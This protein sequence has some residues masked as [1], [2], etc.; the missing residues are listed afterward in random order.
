VPDLSPPPA[1]AEA[2]ME[3]SQ[4][5]WHTAA[6]LYVAH[7]GAPV[8]SWAYG[9]V[10]PGVPMTTDTRF[11]TTCAGKPILAVALAQTVEEGSVAWDEPA[12]TWVPE[13]GKAGKGGIEIRHLVTYSSGLPE[14]SLPPDRAEAL[15]Q[16]AGAPLDYEP[17]TVSAY[18]GWPNW[19]LVGEVLRRVDGVDL[20]TA[21]QRRIFGR[22]GATLVTD[23]TT[24]P[25]AVVSRT[26][27]SP[28]EPIELRQPPA[29]EWWIAYQRLSMR[30]LGSFYVELAR[31]DSPLLSRET[32][33]F[34]LEPRARQM[35]WWFG[36][37]K[38]SFSWSL[39]FMLDWDG[40]FPYFPPRTFGYD[41][42]PISFAF[43]DPDAELVVAFAA[44]GAPGNMKAWARTHEITEAIFETYAP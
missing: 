2:V 7:R 12:A 4:I 41:G 3:G 30:D 40:L 24:P 6:Q 34:M 23:S 32:L 17:G 29:E 35:P 33:E 13:L 20:P 25:A 36:G 15:A 43:A 8:V 10:E 9:E 5:G 38:S 11:P 37:P 42:V 39:G 31:D 27:A 21:L 28:P 14:L 16:V 26:D 1:V 18:N 22:F 19:F 44:D